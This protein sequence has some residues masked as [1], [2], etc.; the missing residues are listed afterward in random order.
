MI[1]LLILLDSA[2]YIVSSSCNIFIRHGIR[3]GLPVIL[4]NVECSSAELQLSH[5]NHDTRFR[6]SYWYNQ[7]GVRCQTTG[8]SK[9]LKLMSIQSDVAIDVYTQLFLVHLRDF[10]SSTSLPLQFP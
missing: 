6:G 8:E 4:N 10:K 3:Q 7:L 2:A 1:Y 5:C 9:L